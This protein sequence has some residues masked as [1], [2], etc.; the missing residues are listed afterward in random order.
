MKTADYEYLF[1]STLKELRKQYEQYEK[2]LTGYDQIIKQ[3]EKE[4]EKE[5]DQW[6]LNQKQK[7]LVKP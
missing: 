5:I 4:L 3:L 7:T 6:K 2:I 1:H